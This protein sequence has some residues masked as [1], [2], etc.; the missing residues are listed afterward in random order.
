MAPKERDRPAGGDPIPN[1]VHQ[2]GSDPKSQRKKLQAPP[3]DDCGQS[4]YDYFAARPDIDSRVRL[5]F[6]DEFPPGV[7][8]DSRCAFVRVF[9]IRNQDGS[10]GT[11]SRAI[12]YSDIDGGTA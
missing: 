1:A 8:E 5:P 4:D 12:F 11:R 3:P 9:I 2:D 10:P 7:L 6:P